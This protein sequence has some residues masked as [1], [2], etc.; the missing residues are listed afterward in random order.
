MKKLMSLQILMLM[1]LAVGSSQIHGEDE[2]WAWFKGVTATKAQ[3]VQIEQAKAAV[4]H[5]LPEEVLHR[6]AVNEQ[7]LEDT[8]TSIQSFVH[9]K[10]KEIEKL[11]KEKGVSEET[12]ATLAV[13]LA[14]AQIKLNY[15]EYNKKRHSDSKHK[16]RIQAI[17]D[18]FTKSEQSL[19][20]LNSQVINN[21]PQFGRAISRGAYRAGQSAIDAG[22]QAHRNV[23][24]VFY[25]SK[26]KNQSYAHPMSSENPMAEQAIQE[27]LRV[28][29][30]NQPNM[31]DND[32]AMN[33]NDDMMDMQDQPMTM[34]DQMSMYDD[35]KPQFANDGVYIQS[36]NAGSTQHKSKN[37]ASKKAQAKKK[38]SAAN[39]GKTKKSS[40]ST[41]SST[42]GSTTT[43]S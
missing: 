31:M 32:Q 1:G 25:G 11:L 34:D 36:Y 5:D 38:S 26:N 23:N 17:K 2:G 13:E 18:S 30:M 4:M 37:A 40:S 6:I 10:N 29:L 9:K 27:A 8:L 24:H 15:L 7:N 39:K 19:K 20:K 28:S 3:D 35:G 41:S 43:Q 16:Q 33:D 21:M 42:S 14:D 22:R 12:V